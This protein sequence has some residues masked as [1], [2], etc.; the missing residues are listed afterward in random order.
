MIE[1]ALSATRESKTLDFKRAFD[2]ECPA[3]WCELVKDL[4]AMANSGG[5]Y[6]LIGVEDD[7]SPS[8]VGAAAP[9]LALDPAK[10]TDKIAKYTGVQ[11]DGFGIGEGVR[12]GQPVA[13]IEVPGVS[14]PLVFNKPGT[15]AVDGNRQKTAFATGT[16]YVRHG[17][18]SEPATSDDVGRML[19]R[20]IQVVRKEWLSGVRRVISAPTGSTI[21]VLPAGVVQSDDPGATPV[22]ITDNPSAPEYRIVAPDA[23]H[24]WRQKELIAEVNRRVAERDRV[25]QYDILAIRQMHGIEQRP[26]YFYRPRYAAPQYSKAFCDW[27]IDKYTGD[28]AFFVKTR[29]AH[30]SR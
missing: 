13:V 24:P 23:T 9:V 14:R 26:E 11:F 15:Y 1:R 10:L 6:I 7:G 20:L 29:A 4:V 25:N 8:Q 19:D 18:K 5:G 27:V 30:K 16:L 2:P 3:E 21:A 28:N 12:N 17:A 22:R